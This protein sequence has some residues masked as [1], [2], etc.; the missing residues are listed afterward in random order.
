M[1]QRDSN[2]SAYLVVQNLGIDNVVD[3]VLKLEIH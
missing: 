2:I 3:V 1:K